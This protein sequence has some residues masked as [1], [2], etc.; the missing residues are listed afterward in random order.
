M[1]VLLLTNIVN[2]SNH[3]KCLFLS[4]NITTPIK[5]AFRV[6]GAYLKEYNRQFFAV[7]LKKFLRHFLNIVLKLDN[8]T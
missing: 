6:R 5:V 3:T 2:S 8:Q 4:N 1:L 7:F